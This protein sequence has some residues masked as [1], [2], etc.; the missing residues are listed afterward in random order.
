[1]GSHERERTLENIIRLRGAEQ[2]SAD[3]E[4]AAVR[5]DLE[6]QL[7]GTVPRSLAARQLGVSHTALNNWIAS[8]DVPVVITKQGR[9]EVPIPALLELR[10]QVAAQRR[11]GRRKLHTLE[12]VM[13]EERRQADRLRPRVEATEL[14]P[15]D[16]HRIAELRSLAYHRALAP[17]LRRSMV[18]QALRKLRRWK[19]EERIDPRYA[20]AWEEVLALPLDEIRRAIAADDEG[21]RDLRQNSPFAGLLSERERRKILAAV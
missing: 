5:E 18:D 16:P 19:E 7:S 15:S 11:S 8:G 14:S 3:P 4:V 20:E 12:P 17:R 6:A 10:Q 13:V 2:R 21:G 1:M 9:K